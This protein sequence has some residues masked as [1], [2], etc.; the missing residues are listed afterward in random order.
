VDVADLVAL[1]LGDAAG[2]ADAGGEVADEGA[3]VDEDVVAE[4]EGAAVEGGHLG[5]AGEG[6]GALVDAHADSAAGGG[7]DDDVGLGAN[8]LDGRSEE[9]TRLAGRSVRVSN[10]E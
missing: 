9:L 1:E 3:G 8:G 7:L 5:A 10:M 6:L 4:V 2:L